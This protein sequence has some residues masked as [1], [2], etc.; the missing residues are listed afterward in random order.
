MSTDMGK[1]RDKERLL[2]E[3]EIIFGEPVIGLGVSGARIL[4]FFLF[5][6]YFFLAHVVVANGL[7][8]FFLA[9][10]CILIGCGR[11]QSITTKLREK[12]KAT[13]QRIV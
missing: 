9:S 10:L 3:R 1:I 12:K 7:L 13:A 2:L 11:K 5:F 8:V 4:D 6:Y